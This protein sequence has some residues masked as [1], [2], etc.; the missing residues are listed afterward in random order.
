MDRLETG[1]PFSADRDPQMNSDFISPA[2]LQVFLPV[3]PVSPAAKPTMT[4]LPCKQFWNI[5]APLYQVTRFQNPGIAV[6]TISRA[7]GWEGS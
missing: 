4:A 2:K 5:H 6:A 1:S 7:V 3:S